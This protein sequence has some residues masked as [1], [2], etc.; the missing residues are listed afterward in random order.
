MHEANRRLQ[1]EFTGGDDDQVALVG[2]MVAAG[3]PI[4]EFNAEDAGLED[5]FIEIT[6]GRVQ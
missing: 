1:F 2:R 6:E 4:L 3:L 5:L